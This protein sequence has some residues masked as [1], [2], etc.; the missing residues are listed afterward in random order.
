MSANSRRSRES[1]K[2]PL[3]KR[4]SNRRQ[5]SSTKLVPRFTQRRKTNREKPVSAKLRR[6]TGKDT[7]FWGA[8]PSRALVAASRRDEL[9]IILPTNHSPSPG[10][11]PKSYGMSLEVESVG[12]NFDRIEVAICAIAKQIRISN[13]I[14]IKAETSPACAGSDP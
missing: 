14:Q 10:S 4:G 9:Q 11:R 7:N 5:Q 3:F 8:R 6:G 12:K 13:S 2:K 1:P